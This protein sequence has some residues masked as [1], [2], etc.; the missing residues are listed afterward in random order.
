MT[1][2]SLEVTGRLEAVMGGICVLEE[3]TDKHLPF[4]V[5]RALMEPTTTMAVSLTPPVN[6]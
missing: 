2:S 3:T 6:L 5:A 4:A 1:R